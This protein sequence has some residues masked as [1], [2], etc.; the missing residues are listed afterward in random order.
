[1]L[2]NIV[3]LECKIGEKIYQ[4]FCDND[5]PLEHLKEAFFQFQKFIGQIED[6]VKA[7]Q[8]EQ[9]KALEVSKE[10]KEEISSEESKPAV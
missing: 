9:K 7:Q 4:L 10:S 1:M 5:S 6:N 3:K 8:E 2:K